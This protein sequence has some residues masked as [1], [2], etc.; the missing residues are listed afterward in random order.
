MKLSRIL[1]VTV[2][3]ALPLGVAWAQGGTSAAS[4]VAG[5]VGAPPAAS[6]TN[7]SAAPTDINGK[8]VSTPDVTDAIK[9]EVQSKASTAQPAGSVAVSLP[10]GTGGRRDPFLSPL[11]MVKKDN[12]TGLIDTVECGAGKRCLVPDQLVLKGIVKSREGMIAMVENQQ[13]KSYVLHERDMVY[14]GSVVKITGDS[15]IFRQSMSD[16]QG[17]MTDKMVVKKVSDPAKP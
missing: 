14:H 15:V 7:P 10:R 1:I 9:A 12:P 16:S 13:Q 8:R 11:V 17:H 6:S 3:M 5:K 2:T 4:S